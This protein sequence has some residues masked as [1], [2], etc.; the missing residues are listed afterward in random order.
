MKGNVPKRKNMKGIVTL[1]PPLPKKG[2]PVKMY[3]IKTLVSI[4]REMTTHANNTLFNSYDFSV[5]ETLDGHNNKLKLTLRSRCKAGFI[6]F[7]DLFH[8]LKQL[9]TGRREKKRQKN[10]KL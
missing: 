8:A 1:Q 2:N 10:S 9:H 6:F 4:K 5:N 3:N 7:L